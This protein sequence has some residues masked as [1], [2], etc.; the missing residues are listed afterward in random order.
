MQLGRFLDN[1]PIVTAVTTEMLPGNMELQL[2]VEVSFPTKDRHREPIW[3]EIMG[4]RK[5]EALG[6]R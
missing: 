5:K 4:R 2:V 3:S 6:D 1:T